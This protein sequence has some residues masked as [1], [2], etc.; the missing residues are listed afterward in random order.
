M[1]SK[2]YSADITRKSHKLPLV[3]DARKSPSTLRGREIDKRTHHSSQISEHTVSR[4]LKHEPLLPRSQKP[5]TKKMTAYQ[6]SLPKNLFGRATGSS[7]EAPRGI[8]RQFLNE[9]T[10]NQPERLMPTPDDPHVYYEDP[11]IFSIDIECFHDKNSYLSKA[12]KRADVTR[13]LQA[14]KGAPFESLDELTEEIYTNR[15]KPQVSK[16]TLDAQKHFITHSCTNHYDTIAHPRILDPQ[17]RTQLGI[18]ANN[19]SILDT[20]H[21]TL[22]NGFNGLSYKAADGTTVKLNSAIAGS[23]DRESETLQ[24][25]R[26]IAPLIQ[27]KADSK[28]PSYCY[29]GRPDSFDKALEQGSMIFFSELDSSHPKGISIENKGTRDEVYTVDYVVNC[30]ESNSPLYKV[31]QPLG[32]EQEQEYFENEQ[33]AFEK[34]RAGTHGDGITTITDPRT[35]RKYKVKF[36]PILFSKQVNWAAR[37][38]EVLDTATS[39]TYAAIKATRKGWK[40]IVKIADARRKYLS[41]DEQ[42]LLDHLL[43]TLE[44]TINGRF[45]TPDSEA[46]ELL[47][48]T[49]LCKLLD[50]PMVWHCKS[51]TDRT[52]VVVAMDVALS[53]WLKLKQPIPPH[54]TDLLH[55]EYFKELFAL[56]WLQGH[57]LTRNARSPDG[58]IEKNGVLKELDHETLG[59][60]INTEMG[61]CTLLEEL[62]PERYLTQY[63]LKGFLSNPVNWVKWIG[64]T[65]LGA[66][67]I[68]FGTLYNPWGTQKPPEHRLARAILWIPAFLVMLVINYAYLTLFFHRA[69]QKKVV[70]FD[71][72]GVGPRR[73]TKEASKYQHSFANPL[74]AIPANALALYE[75][76]GTFSKATP[77]S[78]YNEL[79]KARFETDIPKQKRRPLRHFL[80]ANVI[81]QIADTPKK[82]DNLK[83][84]QHDNGQLDRKKI[85][86][87]LRNESHELQW[88]IDKVK[89]TSPEAL[90]NYLTKTK[91]L[92]EQSALQLLCAMQS[93]SLNPA[94]TYLSKLLDLKNSGDARTPMI[95]IQSKPHGKKIIHLDTASWILRIEGRSVLKEDHPSKDAAAKNTVHAEIWTKTTLQCQPGHAEF[96]HGCVEYG[97]VGDYKEFTER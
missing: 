55:N 19:H 41:K 8:Q 64:Y 73:L 28:A 1:T 80:R 38:G 57:Q 32:V 89:Y 42:V 54:F 36:R 91:H 23:W 51:S 83:A 7:I 12:P 44:E 69:I 60:S 14:K 17:L 85:F 68:P 24:M 15:G 94:K 75:D 53:Q 87:R 18:D 86:D 22:K 49:M 72:L 96:G 79:F 4:S 92:S 33:R 77:Y 2:L 61:Q 45:R 29:T 97:L 71:A 58:L 76:R 65:I 52:S 25:G 21:I 56:N 11:K 9:T 34:L 16:N 95:A 67:T 31:A 48:R 43:Q 81:K 39:G 88:N 40:E 26:R 63:G 59:I 74:Q 47:A 5:F 82:R 50:L 6:S 20:Q 78:K 90:F 62:L 30:I 66:I 27:G 35:H 10:R 93:S 37:L 3:D 46:Q 13:I 84:F 70:N